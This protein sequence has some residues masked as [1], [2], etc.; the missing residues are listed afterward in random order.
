[1][2]FQIVVKI[3]DPKKAKNLKALAQQMANVL[4]SFTGKRT[5]VNVRDFSRGLAKQ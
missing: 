1:M 2:S 5:I 3:R 4:E